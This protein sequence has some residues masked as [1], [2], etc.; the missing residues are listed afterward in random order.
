MK[1]TF[2]TSTEEAQSNRTSSGDPV[3]A[4]YLPFKQTGR[5]FIGK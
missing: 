5:K 3:D 1:E 2:N 4:A